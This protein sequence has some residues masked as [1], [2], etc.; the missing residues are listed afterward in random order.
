MS[1]GAEQMGIAMN[2]EIPPVDIE[3][4]VEHVKDGA[5]V[6]LP[7]A[8]SAEYSGISMV[9]TRAI[10]RKHV[11]GLRLVAVPSTS[12]QGDLLIGAGCVASLQTG[13]ILLYEYGRANRFFAAQE[14]GSI[15]VKDSTCPAIHA[16][17]IAG[18]KGLP[19][20]PVR[21]LIGS[22]ILLHRMADDGW[23]TIDNPFGEDDPVVVV[24][25]LRPDVT[26]LHVPLADRFGNVWIGRRSEFATMALVTFEAF[27]D[28]DLMA[29]EDKAPA[30]IPAFY[31]TALS[32]Q[33]RGSWP[34]HG[35]DAYEEDAEHLREY[36]ELSKTEAGFADYLAGYVLDVDAA[37]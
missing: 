15:V 14:A 6:A 4:L 17:L 27:F 19:F 31:V 25:P 23:L 32:H 20:M 30:T 18:E 10:I 29:D 1:R 5:L 3:S 35:G 11:K 9:A 13:S 34:L 2:A 24:P 8:V 22:D 36:A 26:L 37:A 33:P 21:G 16:A 7:S 28:G 12:L